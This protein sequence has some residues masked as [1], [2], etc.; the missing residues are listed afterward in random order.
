MKV[1]SYC[2][3]PCNVLWQCLFQILPISSSINKHR[4][5]TKDGRTVV[6]LKKILVFS[7]IHVS[8]KNICFMLNHS[9]KPLLHYSIYWYY[10]R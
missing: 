6:V 1:L 8:S 9:L 5:T 10:H 2:I 3:F 4:V 7:S